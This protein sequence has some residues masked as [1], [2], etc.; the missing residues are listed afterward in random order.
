MARVSNKTSYWWKPRRGNTCVIEFMRQKGGR[1]RG[2]RQKLPVVLPLRTQWRLKANDRSAAALHPPCWLLG[3]FTLIDPCGINRSWTNK[4]VSHLDWGESDSPL[5][6]FIP[7]VELSFFLDN[8]LECGECKRHP[9]VT[10]RAPSAPSPILM[11]VYIWIRHEKR[12]GDK[13]MDVFNDP[14]V[15]RLIFMWRNQSL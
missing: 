1:A 5:L 6:A 9:Y 13:L 15:S 2:T 12:R 7:H 14:F 3:H 4:D 10:E 8:Y 11:F